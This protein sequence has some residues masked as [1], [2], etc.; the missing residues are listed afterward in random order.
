MLQAREAIADYVGKSGKCADH[1]DVE[2]RV[3][4]VVQEMLG[5]GAYGSIRKW[6]FHAC[7]SAITMPIDL[8]VPLRYS[9]DGY[10]ES[11]WSK[12]YEFSEMSGAGELARMQEAVSLIEETNEVFTSYNIPVGGARIAVSLAWPGG[13]K[14][15]KEAADAYIIIHGFDSAGRKIE[16]GLTAESLAG[17]ERLQ[18]LNDK[19]VY[20][21]AEFARITGIE[22]SPTN[23]HV[24]LHWYRPAKREFGFL[25][26]YRPSDIRPSFR[27][28][29]I[30]GIDPSRSA[31]GCALVSILGR[32]RMLDRYHDNEVLPVTNLRALE[33]LAQSMF[34][35]DNDN[36]LTAGS[37]EK[38]A[39]ASIAREVEYKRPAAEE[40]FDFYEETAPGNMVGMI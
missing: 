35:A 18:I 25:A 29:R 39:A 26:E 9:I 17:G 16:T 2:R 13:T 32:V 31:C 6:T 10:P 15:K 8:E 4:S 36:I 37:K 33:V 28:F 30:P 27:R 5:H 14:Q 12:W 3:M 40:G 34:A 21:T 22:K 1:P 19:T 7:E 23:N 11:V 38:M 24:R 20:G